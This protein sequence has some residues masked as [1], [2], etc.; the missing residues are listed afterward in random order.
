MQRP[1]NII[2]PQLR[3]LRSAAGLS[4]PALAAKCQRIGWDIE[5]D[6]IAKIEGQTRWVSDAELVMLAKCFG[7]SFDQ[8]LPLTV[9]S[10]KRAR[11]LLSH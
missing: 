10:E 5:R 11:A 3:R 4:Q 1:R 8:L 7:I 2:G 9:A 6:T